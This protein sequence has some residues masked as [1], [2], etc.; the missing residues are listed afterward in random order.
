[1]LPFREWSHEVDI[2]YFH[3]TI[4]ECGER[5]C[6]GD[7]LGCIQF[8]TNRTGKNEVLY[9]LPHVGPVEA[10]LLKVGQRSVQAAVTNDRIVALCQRLDFVFSNLLKIL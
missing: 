2:E 7:V 1:M 4:R 5:V 10:E 6:L 8:L 9:V 3:R